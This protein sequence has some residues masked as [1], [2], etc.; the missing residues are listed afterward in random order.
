V[1][2]AALAVITARDLCE[3]PDPP[4]SAE[5]LGPVLV[6][7]Q[8]TMLG[9]QTGEGKTTLALQMV[10]AMAAGGEFLGWQG[11]GGRA[12]VIDAEQGVRTIK[13]RLR[14]ADLDRSDSI[15]YLVV[16]DGLRLDTDEEQAEGV[17]AILRAG[18]Y[19]LTLA[20]PLYKLQTGDSNDERQAVE[21]MRRLDRWRSKYGFALLL[22][23]H[24]RKP[25]QRTRFSMHEF[26]G[27]SA[28]LRG[29]EVVLGLQRLTGHGRARLHFFKD[30]DGD[31]PQG[32][33]W[34]LTFERGIGYRRD[35]EAEWSR[36]P[37]SEQVADLLAEQPG[38]TY[39]D[40]SERL[41]KSERTVRTALRRI[42]AVGSGER[43]QRW[44]LPKVPKELA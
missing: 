8:R 25:P 38:Q 24:C 35:A 31:L 2:S 26:F 22:L 16:P 17:E 19:S 23:T 15:D 43:P 5:L 21:F 32:D 41:G 37:T 18:D 42:E 27:S 33:A 28:Y 6:R 11:S 12:L 30:R 3:R 39:S 14:E 34:E 29:A 13:R 40:L 1:N 7:G 10:K 4:G 44:S 20:D 36:K 9:G